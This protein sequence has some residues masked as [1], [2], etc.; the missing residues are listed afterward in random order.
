[1]GIGGGGS[2]SSQG[3][4]GQPFFVRKVREAV[5][6]RE[7]DRH[8][9]SLA[10]GWLEVAGAG[11]WWRAGFG[12]GVGRLRAGILLAV[13]GGSGF[14]VV[15]RPAPGHAVSGRSWSDRAAQV[16]VMVAY[17]A[18]ERGKQKGMRKRE[19]MQQIL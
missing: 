16:A 2:A 6:T 14:D 4:S 13:S 19:G 18:V 15:R 7:E 1:V 9:I 12:S 10:R 8:G 11:E 3:P 5:E 17:L